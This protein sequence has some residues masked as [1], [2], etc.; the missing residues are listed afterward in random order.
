MKNNEVKTVED[1]LNLVPAGIKEIIQ[2][3]RKIVLTNLPKGY[4]EIF[5]LGMIIYIIPLKRFSSTHNKL[6]LMLAAIASQENYLPLHLMMAYVDNK[7]L[8]T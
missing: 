1:Y 8:S 6:P 3:V 4:E 7:R 2:T 5:A